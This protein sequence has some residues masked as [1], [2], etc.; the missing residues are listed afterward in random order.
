MVNPK[1]RNYSFKKSTIKIFDVLNTYIFIKKY[2]LKF[3]NSVSETLVNI[4]L[5]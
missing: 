4:F 2:D 1:F 3:L 5:K